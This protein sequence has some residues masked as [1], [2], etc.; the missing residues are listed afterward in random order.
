MAAVGGA[1]FPGLDIALGGLAG[2]VVREIP[3]R[4]DP[5]LEAG[6]AA[7]VS[8][9]GHAQR[10]TALVAAYHSGVAAEGGACPVA[11]GWVR[12]MAGGPVRVIAAGDALVGGV[13]DKAAEVFLSLPA[14]ARA[15]VFAEGELAG[16]AGGL[17]CW[18]EV[19]GIS[20][21]LLIAD[22][23]GGYNGGNRGERDGG[24][25]RVS[26]DEGLLGSWT[27][28][29]GWLVLAEPLTPG[30]LTALAEEA[31]RR[32]RLAA[33]SADRFP[34]REAQA[35][36]LKE[37]HAELRRG[38]SEGFWRIKLVVGAADTASAARVA[39]LF[40]AATD[41]AGLPY[42]LSPAPVAPLSGPS[43]PSRPPGLTRPPAPPGLSGAQ[44]PNL[45]VTAV[46]PRRSTGQPG[47]SRR[48]SGRRRGKCPGCAS[49]CG[50][51]ST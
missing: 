12:G 50:R 43:G 40:C 39:G 17:P 1:G 24:G 5:H 20:D 33:A 32:E 4:E 28:A 31:G 48:W 15:R 29:F 13:D 35:R 2:Y 18:R 27:G 16:L 14:G 11:F 38:V 10:V 23:R 45:A 6:A 19:A 37:R 51:T 22:G 44:A 7:Q 49:C 36:R 26:L 34:E 9:P 3:R 47:C 42:A 46:R 25:G 30:E 8:D 41:L 21:G